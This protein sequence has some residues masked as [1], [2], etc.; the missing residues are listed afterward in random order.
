MLSKLRNDILI[1]RPDNEN[2][3]VTINSTLDN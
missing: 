1:M 2:G 3:V